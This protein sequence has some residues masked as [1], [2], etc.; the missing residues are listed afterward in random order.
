MSVSFV[1]KC[2]GKVVQ[3]FKLLIL[4]LFQAEKCYLNPNKPWLFTAYLNVSELSVKIY[5][6]R[7]F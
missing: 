1:V 3:C 2:S 7:Q 4:T 5:M 6:A